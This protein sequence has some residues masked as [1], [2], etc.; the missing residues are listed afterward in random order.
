MCPYVSGANHMNP[1]KEP[2]PKKINKP[3]ALAKF[4][5][6]KWIQKNDINWPRDIKLAMP[7]AALYPEFEFW[8]GLP[9][10]FHPDNFAALIT[11]KAK[12]Y[13]ATQYIQF[14]LVLPT[15]EGYKL[16]DTKVG[17]DLTTIPLEK[18]P[19]SIMEFCK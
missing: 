5:V 18:K 3:H 19:T 4:I 12:K 6:G 13:L 2:K 7:L 9:V 1:K 8:D 14:K 17:E 16:E 10:R 11:E 15:K